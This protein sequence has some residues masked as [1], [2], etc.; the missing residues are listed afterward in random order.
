MVIIMEIRIDGSVCTCEQG[1]YLI[2]VAR[3]NGIEIPTLCHHEALRGLG[4]CRVCVVEM[5]GKIVPSCM[6][7]VE[8][9][10]VVVTNSSA[11]QEKRGMILAL[12]KNSAPDSPEIAAL[13]QRW[14]A[15]ELSRLKAGEGRC[16][17]CGLCVEACRKMGT[18]AIASMLRGIQKKVSTPYDEPSPACIGCASCAQVCP[19]GAIQVEDCGETRTIW[20]RNFRL[21][22][23]RECGA[24]LGTPEFLDHVQGETGDA[25]ELLCETCRKRRTAETVRTFCGH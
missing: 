13:A 3:R 2:D 1:E 19:T 6:T 22:H 17:L 18:G 4:H 15:P 25:Q 12:L 9:P 21:E 11:V 8:K 16:I 23:C 7:K 24:V 20:K 10:C 5:D 14:N